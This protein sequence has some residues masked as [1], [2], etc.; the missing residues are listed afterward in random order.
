MVEMRFEYVGDLRCRGTHGPSGT[1]IE[2]DAPADNHGKAQRFSPT[3][4]V[5]SA[6][7]T[8]IMTTIAIQARPHGWFVEGMKARVTKEMSATPPRRIARLAVD[9]EM[10]R[11]LPEDQRRQIEAIARSC[12]VHRSLHP[13]VSA[14]VTV[15]WPSS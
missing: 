11:N 6:L 10:P 9:L 2:T 13:D 12:P 7:A 3:D 4:L 14:P 1:V 15:R 8:C 5:G